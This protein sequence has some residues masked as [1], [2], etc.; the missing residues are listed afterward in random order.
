MKWILLGVGAYAVLNTIYES[1]R[2]SAVRACPNVKLASGNVLPGYAGN[3]T[4]G[5][6]YP[7]CAAYGSFQQTWGWFEPLSMSKLIGPF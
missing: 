2:Q 3:V 1:A 5:Q 7:T 4:P 6:G